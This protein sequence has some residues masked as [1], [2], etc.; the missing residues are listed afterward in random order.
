MK[1]PS[2][3][4]IAAI[5]CTLTLAACGGGGGDDTP[6]AG[7]AAPGAAEGQRVALAAAPLLPAAAPAADGA[8]QR[9]GNVAFG[10]ARTGEIEVPPGEVCVL[11]GTRI[12][13]NLKLGA[14]SVLD[15]RD[16]G[17]S[18]NV[19]ADRAAAVLIAGTSSV[20]GSVQLKQGG[21]ATI[22]GVVITGDLQFDDH[23]APLLAQG[24]RIGG[25]LQA[26]T[27]RA[28]LRIVDNRIVGN[29]QCQANQPAPVGSGNTAASI[30]DQC[31]G[32]AA[33]PAPDPLQPVNPPVPPVPPSERP[34]LPPAAAAPGDNVECR[35]QSL[36]AIT[37]ANVQVPAGARC[38]L[39]GT[40]LTGSLQAQGAAALRLEGARL[41]GSLQWVDGG[42]VTASA[43]R[44]EGSVQVERATGL[45]WLQDLQPTG[46]LQ[47]FDNRGG[48]TLVDN[49]IGGNLQCKGN[50]PAPAG[51]GNQAASKQ[52]Q[53][54]GL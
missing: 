44:I 23:D 27:N 2:L 37:V 17:V 30:E 28:G 12:E 1:T 21:Q 35:D 48:A 14:G 34:T 13:G 40:V 32:M 53:C 36:G 9:C 38:E 54:A 18:G 47:L 52:D 4:P 19:Q 50:Q 24:N 11:Q 3:R 20:G 16:V 7:P 43:T 45:L 15:A 31:A 51:S 26:K 29:L 33:G 8:P 39:I 6:T 42:A 22:V 46:D 10:A 5:L 49:R 25:N 41:L